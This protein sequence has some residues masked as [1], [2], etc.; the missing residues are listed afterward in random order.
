MITMTIA[1][2]VSVITIATAL[3]LIDFALRAR[4]A[5]VSLK[6]QGQ[7]AAAGFVPQ[8]DAQVV[9]LRPSTHRAALA[10]ARPIATRLRRRREAVAQA[11]GAA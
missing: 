10:P 7:L 1:A 4:S 9:R 3:T 5:Y 6:R 8:V 11:H 2:L